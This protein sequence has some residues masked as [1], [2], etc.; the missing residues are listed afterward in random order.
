MSLSK[1]EKNLKN[2]EQELKLT[3]DATTDGIWSWDFE[4]HKM[5]FSNKYYKMLGYTSNEFEAT[6]KNWLNLVHPEDKKSIL[7]IVKNFF[8][9]KPDVYENKSRLRTKSGEYRWIRS[10]ATVVKRDSDG[11]PLRMIGSHE[12]ITD[13]KIAENEL[14]A[15]ETRY[16]RMM[17]SMTDPAYICSPDFRIEYMNSA[18]IKKIGHNAVGEIC[19]K[20]I[21]NEED[22]C[23]W[24]AFNETCKG[25][26]KTYEHYDSETNNYYSVNCSPVVRPNAPA[27]KLSIFR[28]ISEIKIAQKE[29]IETEIKFQQAQKMESIG[30]LAG[31]I[32]HNFNNILMVILGYMEAFKIDKHIMELHWEKIGAIEKQIDSA[33]TLTSSLLGFA[34]GGKYS[35]KIYD[36]N[37]I[38]DLSLNL[39]IDTR[40][41][42]IVHKSFSETIMMVLLDKAQMNQVFLNMYINAIQAMPK[43]GNLYVTTTKVDATDPTF[44][45]SLTAENY[46]KISITDEGCGI[47]KKDIG[48]IFDPFY[49][50]KGDLRSGMGLASSYGIV[51]NHKGTITVY[52]KE[53]SGATF[54]VYLPIIVQNEKNKS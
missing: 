22:V 12:D 27:S 45:Y 35:P 5:T 21:Y 7:L 50:T 48:K 4:K 51:K 8:K 33:V 2:S 11:N 16:R 43:G 30:I 29:R 38:V 32:A 52:S 53:G 41:E 46:V 36:I 13:Y 18:M 42:I 14:R 47:K 15:S 23:S 6:Y 24:C 40:R 1:V 10:R 20:V 44:K 49:T 39:F 28:D 25:K 9:Y 3:L 34:K 54:S 26:N 31:A 17:E 19:H 37:K